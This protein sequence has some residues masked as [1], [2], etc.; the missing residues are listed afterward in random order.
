MEHYVNRTKKYHQAKQGFL[1]DGIFSYEETK[2]VDI[3]VIG[4]IPCQVYN[5]VNEF[6]KL[7]GKKYLKEIVIYQHLYKK[8]LIQ[9]LKIIF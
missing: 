9:N 2:D 3:R 1:A 5:A 7:S 8:S 4:E 6:L